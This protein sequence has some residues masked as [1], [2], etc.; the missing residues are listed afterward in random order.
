MFLKQ[1]TKH[2]EINTVTNYKINMSPY[3]G[4]LSLILAVSSLP[5]VY[6]NS[7]RDLNSRAE[8]HNVILVYL[9][10]TEYSNN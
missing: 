5:F 6:T 4:V 3:F 9:G 7:Q 10:Y 8:V 2:R 1:L